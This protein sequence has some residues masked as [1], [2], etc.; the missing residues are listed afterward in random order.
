MFSKIYFFLISLALISGI[1]YRP[2][3]ATSVVMADFEFF[4]ETELRNDSSSVTSSFSNDSDLTN[5]NEISFEEIKFSFSTSEDDQ[6][7]LDFGFV[8]SLKSVLLVQDSIFQIVSSN[9]SLNKLEFSSPNSPSC[10][11]S[12]CLFDF[13]P[14]EK[15]RKFFPPFS[16]SLGFFKNQKSIPGILSKIRFSFTHSINRK[17]MRYYAIRSDG[18]PYHSLNQV[19]IA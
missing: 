12:F 5:K 6:F 18:P 11:V 17:L 10:F 19:Y 16:S 9:P 4:E 15:H 7:D 14:P 8:E 3:H 1:S 2:L 13:L